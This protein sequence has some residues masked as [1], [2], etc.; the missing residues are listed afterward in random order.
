MTHG[1]AESFLTGATR[2][3]DAARILIA[4]SSWVD[5]IGLLATHGLELALKAFLLHSGL[6]DDEVRRE[7]AHD[8]VAL[9][10]AAAQRGLALDGTAPY[11][12]QIV[13]SFHTRP[14]QYRYPADGMASAIPAVDVLDG[15]LCDTL[16]TVAA[17]VAAAN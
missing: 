15:L 6:T 5:P 8:L 12:V 9:W 3:I 7:F 13:S 14:F 1:S 16:A 2:Y 4:A 11:W 10:Q 17:G